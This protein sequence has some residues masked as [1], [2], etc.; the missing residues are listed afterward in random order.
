MH[1]LSNASVA[2]LPHVVARPRYDRHAVTPGIIHLGIGAFHRA[3]QAVYPD[4]CLAA[5][6]ITR[7]IRAASLRSAN[8]RDMPAQAL[9]D[10]FLA[11]GGI[12]GHEFTT[13]ATGVRAALVE[14]VDEIRTHGV[15]A[16][17][18]HRRATH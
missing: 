5:G 12:V 3:H 8:T 11:S 4:D 9:A 17:I 14:A 1:R 18:R 15:I 10:A 7:G 6:E 13:D 2:A 16:A